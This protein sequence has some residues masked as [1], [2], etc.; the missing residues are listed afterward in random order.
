MNNLR[1]MYNYDLHF[2][3]WEYSV[4]MIEQYLSV[5]NVNYSVMNDKFIFRNVKYHQALEIEKISMMNGSILFIDNE[6]RSATVEFKFNKRVGFYNDHIVKIISK[7]TE[8]MVNQNIID[9][10]VVNQDVILVKKDDFEFKIS[11]SSTKQRI[12]ESSF[13][14]NV[15]LLILKTEYNDRLDVNFEPD[16][17]VF[18]SIKYSNKMLD[19]KN[20]LVDNSIQI[21]KKI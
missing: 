8:T 5:L 12:V 11:P 19:T 20:R 9:D 7:F 10:Y 2:K 13:F 21:N 17:D 14:T 15:I 4:E 16:L 1:E 18:K 6:S 3:A